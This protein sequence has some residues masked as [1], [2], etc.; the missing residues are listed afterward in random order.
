M[1]H[2]Q[3]SLWNQ[4]LVFQ[5]EIFQQRDLKQVT[6]IKASNLDAEIRD[7]ASAFKNEIADL[8]SFARFGPNA[9]G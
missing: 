2:K 7:L 9:P 5:R 4:L 1:N 8:R 3:V 6:A